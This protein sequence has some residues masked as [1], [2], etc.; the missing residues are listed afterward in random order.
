MGAIGRTSG[1]AAAD[2]CGV[3]RPKKFSELFA[4]LMKKRP[5]DRIE[6]ARG[7]AKKEDSFVKPATTL[8]R[9]QAA[10][11]EVSWLGLVSTGPGP[12]PALHMHAT[13]LR[14]IGRD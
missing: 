2:T 5:A 11:R 14:F 13:L 10:G 6:R 1:I 3:T 9:S 12:L 4:F 7:E 8:S